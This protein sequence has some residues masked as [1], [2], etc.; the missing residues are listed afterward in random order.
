[1]NGLGAGALVLL[2]IF[3]LLQ[4]II[5]ISGLKHPH[6]FII[7]TRS[8]KSHAKMNLAL[9]SAVCVAT[10]VITG[11]L[12]A[13]DSLTRT[14][15][16]AAYDNLGE[17]DEV[18]SSDRFFNE[19]VMGRLAENEDLSNV[20][21]HLAPLIYLSG[22]VE[23]PSNS[24][25]TM[26]ANIIG[27]DNT[28][29]DFGSLISVEG[30]ELGYT[31]EANEVFINDALAEEI[32]L[33]KGDRVNIS[34]SRV[35]KV[36]EAIFLGDSKNTNLKVQFE[37]KDIVS[38]N[39]LGR[40]QLNA[41]RNAPQ[42]IYVDIESLRL[43]FKSEDAVNMILVSNT[44][45]EKGGTKLC[46]RVSSDLESA[47]D[48]ALGFE[49]AGFRIIQ[50]TE[51]NYVA[52][53]SDDIFFSYD[54]FEL[55]SDN[56]EIT[57]M[58]SSS[59]VLTYF[60][61]TLT[62]ESYTVA[63]STISAYD[64]DI[65]SEFGLFTL[66]GTSE[67]VK[68]TLAENEIIINSWTA[69][70]L[71]A[72][73]GDNLQ[74][75]YSVMDE[76][77][78]VQYLSTNF[79]IKHIVDIEGK[80]NDS[81]LMPSFPG[82]EGKISVF[83]WDPP[84]PMNLNLITDDDEQYWEDYEGTPKAFIGLS[85]ASNLWE[86]DI[87][88]ITQV[89]IAPKQGENLSE[90]T[91]EVE[92]VLNE[93]VGMGEASLFIKS[94]KQDA[95]KSAEGITLFTEMFL[96]FST[97]CIIAAAVLI[98]LLI[99]LRVE[100]RMA[101]IGILRALGFRIGV[102]NH[103]LLLE[104][105]VIAIIGSIL[106]VAFGLL[107]G[108]FLIGGMNTFW[109]SIMEGSPVNFHFTLDSLIIGFCLGIIIS[110]ITMILALRHESKKTVIGV[111]RGGFG[112]RK[113]ERRRFIP[114]GLLIIGLV[115]LLL[116]MYMN[117]EFESEIGLLIAG[118]GPLFLILSL[119]G[120]VPLRKKNIDHRIGLFIVIY[121]IF[122][123]LFFVDYVPEILLFF[124]SGFMFLCGFLLIFYHVLLTPEEKSAGE[125]KK[126]QARSTGK[127]LFQ[128]AQKN[129]ARRPKRT[130]FTVFLF[131][132]TL[133]VLVSLTINLQGAIYD[134]EKA[135][136][137]SGGG[138]DIMAEST[139]PIFANLGDESSRLERGIHSDV[140]DDLFVEQFK[141]KGDVGGTCSNLNREATPMIIG[142]NESFFLDN[143]FVF[144]SHES[145]KGRDNPWMLL[146]GTENNNEIPAIGDYNTVVWILG[147]D[148]GSSITILD[149]SGDAV[150]LRIVGIIGNSIFQGSL[151]ISDGNFN[152]L[153]PTNNGYT[154]FLFKSQEGDL[155]EQILELES[156]LTQYGLDAYSVESV[157]VE[158]IL[159]ENTYIS[160]FQV[161]LL[162]GLIIGTLGF[163]I[164]A[165]RN[166]LERRRELGILRAIGFS[167]GKVK[168]ILIFENSY[169]I[170]SGIAIGTLSG[171]LASSVYLLKL[172]LAVTSWP[173][174]YVL[175]II[176]VSFGIAISSAIIPILKASKMAIA[177][178]IRVSE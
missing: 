25:R 57:K 168:K 118:L 8:I 55:I 143:S 115:I 146:E 75:N 174:L 95:L 106:G 114:I 101:E 138:Y 171:I 161:L 113:S 123:T 89:R 176:M 15:E 156:A 124:V 31:L 154:L 155:D 80:A 153:Y 135:V 10:L 73:V 60:Y 43:L 157:V 150:H 86:T 122:L 56:P 69:E 110:V 111:L 105:L 172:Q 2:I 9:M 141:T 83:D 44:G 13:G 24:A 58:N 81:M 137:E 19:S 152:S 149:E 142:A 160:I 47:L 7:A 121:T 133:F 130:M 26:G 34:F 93:Y 68:G 109:S 70:R 28:F 52:L 32:G 173:W 87:G 144:I 33:G 107:F 90:L 41:N 21:D 6:V 14:I 112:A 18:I 139:N 27:F 175:G 23:N 178:A 129:A 74:M 127:W 131:S 71:Q 108:F 4:G 1:M 67:M 20:I 61:N 103:I 66:N 76:F 30:S 119:R 132:L 98:M 92:E 128:L 64:S 165:Y 42:N 158:N 53:E 97:A 162:F 11:S 78:N 84:F 96:A 164:V 48:E 50:N 169:I 99:T 104:G 166:T 62:H 79:T 163:G 140:F 37:V 151:I 100:S 170:L 5:L 85:E 16:D 59:P 102:I 125:I 72:E 167:K 12:I 147:L 54:F 36:F 45:D 117:I 82:I 65:D 88:N 77:Y 91:H 94:V 120:F 22:I 145:L 3:V 148:I 159:I 51:K 17:V 177:E 49:D 35:D 40:F 136:A 63:Y 116:P 29:L 38:T 134:V 46:N 126:P 39:G